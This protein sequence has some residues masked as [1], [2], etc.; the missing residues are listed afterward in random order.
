M[1]TRRIFAVTVIAILAL[2]AIPTFAG[3]APKSSVTIRFSYRVDASYAADRPESEV[4]CSLRLPRGS[5]GIEVLRAAVNQNCI[6]S[7]STVREHRRERLHCI[8]HVCARVTNAG[9]IVPDTRW[10]VDWTGEKGKYRRSGLKGYSAS[11]G[12]SFT[13]RLYA[14]N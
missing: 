11:D 10:D 7:F 9:V 1:L 4:S 14:V 5:N 6:R 12:D 8:N 13:T 2:G 3:A